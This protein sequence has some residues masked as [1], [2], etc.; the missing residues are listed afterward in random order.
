VV[1]AGALHRGEDVGLV[2]ARDGVED[3]QG[4]LWVAAPWVAAEL[5]AWVLG[6]DRQTVVLEVGF[7]GQG[8]D[9]FHSEEGAEDGD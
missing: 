2:R 1:G 7:L 3:A 5:V 6:V 9:V 4:L 8:G